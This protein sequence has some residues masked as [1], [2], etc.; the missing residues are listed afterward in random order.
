MIAV[1]RKPVRSFCGTRLDGLA[2]ETSR[3][4][5]VYRQKVADVE[6]LKKSV[7]ARAFDGEL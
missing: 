3:L 7:L 2:R 6:E 4:E 5:E 1:L